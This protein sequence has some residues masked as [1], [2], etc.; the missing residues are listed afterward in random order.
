MDFLIAKTKSKK[1]PYYM[2]LSDTQVFDSEYDLSDFRL[3][4]D[5]YKLQ[6]NEWFGVEEF[7]LK[8]Y[9]LDLL[10]EDFEPTLYS[11]MER[12]SYN[13]IV[14]IISIQKEGNYYIFQKVTPSYLYARHKVISWHNLLDPS[15][16]AH[17]IDNKD[18]LVIKTVPD[19][20]Y[21][22]N[23]DRLYFKNLGSITSI[24]EGID[25][26]YREATDSEV[27]EFLALDIINLKEG[28]STK[29]VKQSNRRRIKEAVEKYANFTEEQKKQIPDYVKGY[30][31]H[32]FNLDNN[33]FNISR[34]KDLTEFLN[35][36]NQ[37]YY[38]TEID[39]EKRVARSV[40]KLQ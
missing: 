34:E 18:V 3:Y 17:L 27:A 19:C 15:E 39:R 6:E 12:K 36:L 1:E 13:E 8:G 20:I 35:I 16:Q 30:C 10:K 28:F 14:Y 24:F 23:E 9:C 7:S 26:L 5:E 4:D 31:P 33:K 29:Q 37:R 38:T 11:F 21:V 22:K 25:V 40:I 2:V 32:L